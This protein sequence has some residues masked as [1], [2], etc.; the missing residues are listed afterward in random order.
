MK[1]TIVMAASLLFL[2]SGL[3]SCKKNYTCNCSK[4]YSSGTGTSTHD[5]SVYTY[6]DTRVRAED[7]CNDNSETNSDFFG[8][9]TINC[10]ID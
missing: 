10:E 9:Y 1:K 4:T 6:K 2:G 8:D 3:V 5:Y 7:R